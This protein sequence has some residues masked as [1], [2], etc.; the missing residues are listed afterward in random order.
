MSEVDEIVNAAAEELHRGFDYFLC[1]VLRLRD[2]GY[3]EG[4]ATRGMAFDRADGGGW[5]QPVE[6]GSDRALRA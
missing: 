5:S 1:A 2:D 6:S 3:L 4:V